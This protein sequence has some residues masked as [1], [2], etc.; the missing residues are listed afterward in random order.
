MKCPKCLSNEISGSYCTSDIYWSPVIID[1]INHD[2]DFNWISASLRCR[3]CGYDWNDEGH[4]KCSIP[5]CDFGN[6]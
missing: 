3:D 1:G 2:H 4:Y 6:L 5:N